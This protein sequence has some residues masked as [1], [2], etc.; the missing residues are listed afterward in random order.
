MLVEA[1]GARET[2]GVRPRSEV[3]RPCSDDCGEY[4]SSPW[5]LATA[6]CASLNNLSFSSSAVGQG[7]L[8]V[9]ATFVGIWVWGWVGVC[10][11]GG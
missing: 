7:E 9:L 4:E 10:T 6:A 5:V 1:E 3:L 11:L 8:R 2:S